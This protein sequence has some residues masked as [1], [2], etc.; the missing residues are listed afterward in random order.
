MNGCYTREFPALLLGKIFRQNSVLVA[1]S[2]WNVLYNQFRRIYYKTSIQS[3]QT[4]LRQLG[5]VSLNTL[6]PFVRL[7]GNVY[8][9]VLA[10][11]WCKYVKV[12]LLHCHK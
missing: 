3:N 9:H 12:L 11:D 1:Y 7:L 10:Q 4:I 6:A 2:F 8:H 5:N